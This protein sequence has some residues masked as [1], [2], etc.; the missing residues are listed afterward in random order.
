MTAEKDSAGKTVLDG[1]GKPKPA[2][3]RRTAEEHAAFAALHREA[4]AETEDA[5]LRAFLAFLDRWTPDDFARRGFDPDA[6]DLNI[7]FRLADERVF[8]HDR[9]AARELWAARN[10]PIEDRET[11]QCLITGE[12]APLARLHPAIKGV[13]GAQSSGAPLV[14]FN[15]AAY[16]S[17]GHDRGAN[18]P[19]SERAAFAYATALNALLASRARKLRI[20]D[21]TT[22]F[23]ADA[24]ETGEEAAST[25]EDLLLS[26][27]DPSVDDPDRYDAE[28]MR[29][30]LESIAQGRA[31]EVD[32]RLDPRTRIH[33]L[34]LSPNAARLAVRFWYVGSFGELAGHITAHWR[35]LRLEPDPFPSPPTAWRLLCETAVQGKNDNI[36]PLLEGQLMRA[37]LAGERYP[38]TLLTAVIGRI[39]ADG[40]ANGA[41][42][43]ICKAVVTR[44]SR[45][46]TQEEDVPVALDPDSQDIAY[47]LGRLF[48]AYAYAERSYADR[49]ATIRDK[50]MA[51]ASATPRRTFPI[52]MRGYEHNR[53]ALG[54]G[55]K[56][57]SMIRADQ[58]VAAIMDR[59]HGDVPF[60]AALTLE[61]QARF[62]VG[63]YHQ[64]RW[65]Y[66]RAKDPE[67]KDAATGEA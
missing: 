14:S 59:Y 12:R 33:V 41:R 67:P 43:A 18:A 1:Q 10:A 16:E 24:N 13:A 39:R 57:G 65:F 29:A 8:L 48:A 46:A 51:S 38:R 52:L 55:E 6:L 27:L 40:D 54:K 66:T 11:A 5:G 53:S 3:G 23:W 2:Q 62:F 32:A 22:V 47:N 4:L 61:E 15:S 9:A 34:G 35:D 26:V 49:N 36:P 17:Y 37:I 31:K 56:V 64:E 28:K 20:G 7:V 63:Y 30:A 58:A 25:A 50:Y 45:I 44:Q 60:P 42:V 21:A 19:V